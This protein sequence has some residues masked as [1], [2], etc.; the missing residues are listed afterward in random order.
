MSIL[1]LV[2]SKG[3]TKSFQ[4]G[5]NDK[6]CKHIMKYYIWLWKKLHSKSFL[7]ASENVEDIRSLIIPE[8]RI[9]KE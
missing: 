8:L 9:T 4:T 7:E 2:L 3:S 6:C 5:K 1:C